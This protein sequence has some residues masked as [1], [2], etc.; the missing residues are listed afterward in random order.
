MGTLILTGWGAKDYAFAGAVACRH[1]KQADIYGMSRGHLPRYLAEIAADKASIYKE[2]VIIGIGLE[3]APDILE[4]ALQQLARRKVLVT[5][6]SALEFPP[7]LSKECR[8][9]LHPYVAAIA[10]PAVVASKYKV[11]CQDLLSLL[12]E[13]APSPEGKAYQ[14]LIEAAGYVY[15][16]YQDWDAYGKVIRRLAN[17]TEPANWPAAE[18]NLLAQYRK[19]GARE[20]VGDSEI[21]NELRHKI[22]MIAKHADA[23]VLISGETGTGKETV[24][25]FLHNK[26]PRKNEPFIAFNCANVTPNLLES[27]FFGHEK[28]AFTSASDRYSG[29]FEQANGGTLF[30][31]EIGELP[32]EVQGILLRVLEGGRFMRLGGTQEIE[33]NVR[34]LTASNRN[35]AQL[36]REGKFRADLY[37]RLNVIQIR[38]P[39]LREHKEDIRKIANGFWKKLHSGWLNADQIAALMSYDYPGNVRELHNLLERAC[40]LQEYDF[41]KLLSDHKAINADLGEVIADEYPD[42]LEAATRYHIGKIV[43]RCGGNKSM[44]EKVL[45]VTRNTIR[46]YLA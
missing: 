9:L 24:A 10:L 41:E 29:L 35:I 27:R 22:N 46:K 12:E 3:S 1:F 42:E 28:G 15:R 23:R 5:W 34:L 7:C 43:A 39:S 17:L 14:Q 19:Y 13:K 30:L 38:T 8:E 2:I 11:E 37:Q 45:K 44:A 33:V 26:S 18:K 25:L 6:L 31:D 20:L 16:N 40:V 4:K 36:V 32:L 21:M